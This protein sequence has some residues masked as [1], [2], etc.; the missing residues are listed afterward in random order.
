MIRTIARRYSVCLGFVR[1]CCAQM[2]IIGPGV[3]GLGPALHIVEELVGASFG[4][5]DGGCLVF[6]VCVVSESNA[7]RSFTEPPGF[8]ASY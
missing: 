3:A 7:K 6:G 2:V 4:R 1:L 8:M 5:F